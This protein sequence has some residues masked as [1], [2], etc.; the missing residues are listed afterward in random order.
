MLSAAAAA[1]ALFAAAEIPAGYYSGLNGKTGETLKDATYVA[2][3]NL[4]RISSYSDLPKYFEKTDVYPEKENGRTRWWDMYSNIPLYAPSFS[5]LN[6]EH[7]FP[8]SW[9]GGSTSV[10]AYTDL[11]HLYPSEQ[12]ANMAKSN[13]P[14]GTV[15]MRYT[16]NFDNGVV[17]VGYAVAGQ[18]GG[19]KYVFEPSDEYKGD[20]A[21]TYFYMVTCYQDY[22]WADK[23][24]W[25]LQ[26][27]TYPTLAQWSVD[28]LLAWAAQDPVSQKEI[29]RNE[30]VYKAQHNRNPFID[31]PNLAEYIWGSK[32]GEA[33]DANAGGDIPE[34]GGDPNLFTPVQ[35]SALDFGEVAIGKTVSS[36][37]FFHGEHLTGDLSVRV[38]G[39][40]KEMFSIPSNQIA[41]SLVNSEDGYW[42]VVTYKPTALGSHTG[43]LLISDG[44]LNGSR[45]VS[46]IGSCQPV[47]TLTACT[48]TEPSDITED[49][50]TANWTAP[51]GEVVDYFVV[52]RTIY[53]GSDSRQEE[54][55]AEQNSLVITGF[56]DSD[57]EAYSVQSSRLGYLSP[58]SN[59]VFVNRSGITGVSA[60]QPL[61]A[62]PQPG[63]TIII[64]C[65]APHHNA[66]IYDVTGR[67]VMRIPSIDNND[68]IALPS[69]V[70]ILV[71]DQTPAPVKL[72]IR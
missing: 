11:N 39:D 27:N 18:G 51:D 47:P 58:M 24:M 66:R 19:A 44:G 52:T 2:I 28:L 50:Y 48:A 14:L 65:S 49:S 13:Y 25:M 54:L 26:Q 56:S 70:F 15:D 6:R 20:F 12:A 68:E 61:L 37:L 16:P 8:K 10:N 22:T 63:G 7:S 71:T 31:F 1:M 42:L 59:V 35:D 40:N 38:Y 46:L 5:G 21:R 29:D 67:E 57:A 69:G 30:Q 43:R 53:S 60:P 72:A 62:Y 23:Y 41:T 33:F 36:R 55:V 4:S 17:K 9:W 32:K 3:H 34:P 45:G 64:K